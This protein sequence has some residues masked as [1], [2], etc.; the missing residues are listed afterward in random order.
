MLC[1]MWP[2]HYIFKFNI[3][4]SF[5]TISLANAYVSNMYDMCV[6]RV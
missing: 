4:L 6:I 2:V 1:H 3:V 5:N